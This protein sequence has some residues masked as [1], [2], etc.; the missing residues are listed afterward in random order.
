MNRAGFRLRVMAAVAATAGF[1]AVLRVARPRRVVVTGM[2]MAPTLLPGDR[3]LVVPSRRLRPGDLVAVPD[4]RRSGRL[5]V[6]RVVALS[7]GLV[8]LRGDD[9][10]H[11]TDSRVFGRVPRRSVRGRVVRRYAPPAR[12][13]P[14]G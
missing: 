4:P 7:G 2:S 14:V 9:P 11:S 6:K 10:R 5:L 3:L 1:L 13:G 8:E 12:R